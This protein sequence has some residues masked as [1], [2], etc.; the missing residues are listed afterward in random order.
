MDEGLVEGP[1]APPGRYTV[2]LTVGGRSYAQPFTVVNDPR[3][4][5]T[6]AELAAQHALARRIHDRIDTLVAAVER[7]EQ[8]ER[9][10]ASWAEW[11]KQRPEAAR[12]KS[13]ADSLKTKLEAVRGRLTEPHAHADEATLHW[14]IQIYNQLL[15]LNAMVQSADAAPTKQ[16]QDVFQELSG[17]LD[18]E[19]ARLA[20]LETSELAA[21]NRLL[22]DLNV[23]AV[24]A[25]TG[26]GGGEK[27]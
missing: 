15:T 26:G 10:L 23:P 20:S 25:G 9:Q 21:F 11:T 24:G 14:R 7:I 5:T 8:A 2:K 22:R 19:L 6:L 13:Q 1:V 18:Q 3:V 27:R 12:I 16:E 4:K 17:R